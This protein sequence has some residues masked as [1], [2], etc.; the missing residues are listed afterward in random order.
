VEGEQS[1]MD[2][3]RWEYNHFKVVERA[4]GLFFFWFPPETLCP[5]TLF[6]LGKFIRQDHLIVGCDPGYKRRF[7]VKEQLK[8]ERPDVTVFDSLDAMEDGVRR[9]ALK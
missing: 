3:V 8:L 7:D 4:E 6:E 9:W 1:A 5:I 2:Q